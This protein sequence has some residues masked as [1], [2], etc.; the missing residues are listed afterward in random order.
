VQNVQQPAHLHPSSSEDVS[1]ST[2]CETTAAAASAPRCI[3][4]RYLL[5]QRRI[6]HRWPIVASIKRATFLKPVQNENLEAQAE[7]LIFESKSA[8][9]EWR[10]HLARVRG[11]NFCF[12]VPPRQMQPGV[13]SPH[14]KVGLHHLIVKHYS[15]TCVCARARLNAHE[16]SIHSRI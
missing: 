3:D 1:R 14:P 6:T 12:T 7:Q 4:A 15:F 10:G 11:T 5:A 13:F 16:P 2:G 9:D 8:W